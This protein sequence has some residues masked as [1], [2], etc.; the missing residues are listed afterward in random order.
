[1][2]STE[3]AVQELPASIPVRPDIRDLLFNIAEGRTPSPM[4][5][6]PVE[7]LRFN[8]IDFSEVAPH[9]RLE[10]DRLVATFGQGRHSFRTR[11]LLPFPLGGALE[12]T[13][14]SKATFHGSNVLHVSWGAD[15]TI[16]LG[17][18]VVLNGDAPSLW[19]GRV[20]GAKN[21]A[22]GGNLI[23]ERIGADGLR[24]GRAGHLRLSG[25]YVYYLVQSGERSTPIWHLLVDTGAGVPDEEVLGRD[26][27]LLQFVLGR[28]LRIANLVGVTSDGRAMGSTTGTGTRNNL[29]RHSVPPVPY[30][31]NNDAWIDECWAAL[32][33][34]G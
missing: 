8:D 33:S 3:P 27:L 5:V 18:W 30:G 32:F 11:E 29:H 23:V 19:I 26:F 13:C 21:L 20:E 31:Q 9:V 17:S 16:E 15:L 10:A 22:F 12:G 6:D 7:H 24:L 14:S 25:T 4:I 2:T 1:M 34:N 28:Q